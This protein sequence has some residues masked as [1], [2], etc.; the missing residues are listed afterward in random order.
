MAVLVL[1]FLIVPFLELFVI[2]RVADV[3][4]GWYTVGLLVAMSVVGG[5]MMKREGRRV[6]RRFSQQVNEGKIPA[7]DIAD[8]VLLLGAG[9]LLMTPGFAT[10]IIGLLAVFPPT[11]AVMRK[12]LVKRFAIRSGVNLFDTDRPTPTRFRRGPVYDA[13]GHDTP[14][15]PNPPRDELDR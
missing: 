1:L 5:W 6:W 3:I 11:R 2:L 12:V 10:D 14:T 4:G 9:A 15:E 7:D 13:T 8:G